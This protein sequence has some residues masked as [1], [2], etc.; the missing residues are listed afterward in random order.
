M[1]KIY[2]SS[3]S[4]VLA[5]ALLVFGALGC[6]DPLEV[7][8]PNS[9]VEDDLGNP[10]GANG[11][12]NGALATVAT[13]IGYVL[14]PFNTA[15]D[16]VIWTGS[17]DAWR[18]LDFGNV[19]FDGNEFT[20]NAMKFLHEGRWM[21]D[22]AI[23]QLSAFDAEGVLPDRID[24]ARSYLYAGL[25]RVYIADWFDDWAFSDK[26]EPAP[27]VGE[28]NMN[29]VYT[30]A[31]ANLDKAIDI[32]RSEGN[33][34]LE[35]RALAL[36]ARA[37][38]ALA[39]WGLLNPKGSAPGN[40]WV[41]AGKADAQ[42]ALALMADDSFRWRLKYAPGAEWN[43]F[44]WQVNGRLEL[45]I[46]ALPNDPIDGIEDP[47][48]AAIE[49]DFRDTATYNGTNYAPLTVISA[50]EM[51]LIVA[52]AELASGNSAGAVSEMNIV[53]ALDGLTAIT[54]EDPG[55][56]LQHERRANLFLLGRRLADMYRFGI[57]DPMWQATSDAV[58]TPGS[59]LPITISEI[60]SNP[61]IKNP[62][63][64]Q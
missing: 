7:E 35:A 18:E 59:F 15:T 21:A 23:A 6:S 42:A 43:D 61:C 3:V 38:H 41:S 50:R 2:F 27:S 25:V 52:E 46:A 22:K 29:G 64:C 39:V 48:M 9:L 5:A 16:E 44:S 53:R 54:S 8:N 40:P 1:K 63:A 33:T 37:K 11:V 10:I 14:A 34:V 26:T 51:H 4:F 32:A 56:M 49:A 55:A 13:G 30:D 45:D 58:R 24:L 17:R 31:I 57:Q 36:R 20:D 19:A 60:Q 62:S 12:A 47:R 28:D